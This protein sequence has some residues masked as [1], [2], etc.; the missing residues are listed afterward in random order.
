MYPNK[1]N[2]WVNFQEF[3]MLGIRLFISILFGLDFIFFHHTVSIGIADIQ[4]F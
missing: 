4:W 1:D 3:E 2:D